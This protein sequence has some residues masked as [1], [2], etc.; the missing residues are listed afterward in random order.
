MQASR[1][2]GKIESISS[3]KV[4]TE[5]SELITELDTKVKQ[6]VQFYR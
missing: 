3:D 2:K 1:L 5:D 6:A 4:L